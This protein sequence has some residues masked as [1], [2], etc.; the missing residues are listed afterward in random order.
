M[1]GI[2]THLEDLEIITLTMMVLMTKVKE[3]NIIMTTSIDMI[4]NIRIT[5][6]NI[7][8]ADINVIVGMGT[9]DTT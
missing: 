1:K 4:V 3:G 8:T 2:G 7:E 6:E 9:A 5:N